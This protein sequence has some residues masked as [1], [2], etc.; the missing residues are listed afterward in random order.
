MAANQRVKPERACAPVFCAQ[1]WTMSDAEAKRGTIGATSIWWTEQA[2]EGPREGQTLSRGAS[3][4]TSRDA[5]TTEF[6]RSI[7]KVAARE[8]AL[9]GYTRF[10]HLTQVSKKSLLAIHGV[11]PKSLNILEEELKKRGLRYKDS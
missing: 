5:P 9:S 1:P 6:P 10:E 4:M 11:G 8:L 7:G 2:V 3:H